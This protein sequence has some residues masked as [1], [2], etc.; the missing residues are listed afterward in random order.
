MTGVKEVPTVSK[1]YNVKVLIYKKKKKVFMYKV[2]N[3]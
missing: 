1:Y 3:N 2:F